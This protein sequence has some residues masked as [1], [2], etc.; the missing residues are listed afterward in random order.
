MTP[1][2][3]ESLAAQAPIVL[4]FAT[5]VFVLMREQARNIASLTNKFIEFMQARDEAVNAAIREMVQCLDTLGRE[6]R[7]HD[8][9]VRERWK[10]LENENK[11]K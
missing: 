7:A 11:R 5:A 8:Q 3:W 1:A 9:Y 4:I 10:D 6:T 2:G